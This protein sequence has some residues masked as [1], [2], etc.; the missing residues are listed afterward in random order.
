M[1]PLNT[2]LLASLTM[3][4]LT[5]VTPSFAT[6]IQSSET[7]RSETQNTTPANL[8]EGEVLALLDAISIQ[9]FDIHKAKLSS[10]L[11]HIDEVMAPHG[12]QILFEQVGDN[13]PIVKLKTRNLSLTNNLSYLCKQ[14]SYAWRVENGVVVVGAP[15]AGEQMFTEI[16]S[17]RSPTARKLAAI[18]R[19]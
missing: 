17:L 15:G 1:K 3:I 9:D 12:V 4:T 13:D 16:Y 11:A 10:A 8:T 19:K 14:G 2:T 5:A 7:Y 6:T 18:G